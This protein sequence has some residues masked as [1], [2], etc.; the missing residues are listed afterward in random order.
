MNTGRSDSLEGNG[1]SDRGPTETTRLRG[2][3]GD[4][5]EGGEGGVPTSVHAAGFKKAAAA[6]QASFSMRGRGS[7][8]VSPP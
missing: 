7:F 4:T 8:V 5:G 2:M 3:V 6:L 1:W